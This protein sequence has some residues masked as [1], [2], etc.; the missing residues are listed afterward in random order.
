MVTTEKT[1]LQGPYAL[2]LSTTDLFWVDGSFS[3][4][5]VRRA[6]L[7]S[8]PDS[9]DG[10]CGGQAPGGCF[11]DDLCTGYGDCCSDFASACP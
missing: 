3:S 7:T 5:A 4:K 10:Q 6:S 9:C 8:P 11:C 1:G 2:F